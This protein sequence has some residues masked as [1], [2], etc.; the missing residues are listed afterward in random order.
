MFQRGSTPGG[1]SGNKERAKY[2][3]LL[4]PPAGGN[5][6]PVGGKWRGKMGQMARQI[7]A[8]GAAKW[9]GLR[10]A[11]WARAGGEAGLR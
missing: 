1:G 8:N 2:G 11:A 5:V 10:R 4:A 6:A 7:G 3:A 9:A